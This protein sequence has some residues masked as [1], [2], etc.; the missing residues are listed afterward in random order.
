MLA[1]AR[2]DCIAVFSTNILPHRKRLPSVWAVEERFLAEGQSPL[3]TG[4]A[5]RYRHDIMPHAVEPMDAADDPEINIIVLWFGR[6]MAKT[7]GV[8]GNIVGRTVTDDPGNIYAMGP[9]DDSVYQF[10]RD[11]IEPM[12]ESTP[13]LQ[14]VFVEK[15]SRD[16]G[17]TVD[18]KRFAGGSLYIVNAGSPSKMRGMA[19]KVVLIREVDAFPASTKNEGDPVEKALGRAEGFGDAIK[20]LESTGTLAP[21]FDADGVKK[22]NSRI[23]QWYER[24]DQRKWFCPCRVC[25]RLQWLKFEQI[26]TLTRKRE[27]EFYLCE[28]CDADHNEAQWRRMVLS[29]KWFPTA[30]L[31]EIDLSDIANTF[32]KARAANPAVRSYWINGFNSLLPKGKGYR[33]K[34]TQFVE[35][36][37][38][39]AS[40]PEAKRVWINEVDTTL[41]DPTAEGE[42]PPEWKPVYDRREDYATPTRIIVPAG[43]LVLCV[44]V[45]VHKNRLEVN[46]G[47]YGRGEE[48]WGILH[49]VLMGEVQDE[50]VWKELDKELQREF[51]H[52]LGNKI[53]LS[54]GLID[55]GKW[56]EWI[57]YFLRM[58][59]A[60]GSPVAGRV[61]ACRG[62]SKF[63]HPLIDSRYTS[64]A[65]QLKGHWIGGDEAK[66]LIYTRLR[67]APKE[68]GSLPTGWRHYPMSYGQVHFEQ[69]MSERVTIEYAGGEEIRRYKNEA[70]AR[71][72]TLDAEVYQLGA[73][74]LRRWNMDAIEAELT[75]KEEPPPE[76]K[77]VRQRSG[78]SF[79]DWK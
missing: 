9:T 31:S 34:L 39:V 52:E 58:I 14:K 66:D 43:A 29:A 56:P 51:Q 65:K 3:S 49:N 77:P 50:H 63:P 42:K 69:L 7:E 12:I 72:E 37:A 25:G 64:I 55:A 73:F 16:S 57:Y 33:T 11:M 21:T 20:V 48:Y 74:R 6:R 47:A 59:R 27:T 18:Y 35:E 40:D 45:D 15:K 70:H 61:R 10:S 41:W 8:C 62:A 71:N 60:T 38:R 13:A 28:K 5:I 23:H 53:G 24:G 1:K 68:D 46:W 54:F 67:L 32:K 75:R 76:K 2:E 22:Y 4:H 79:W 30:G 26:K 36:A 19:A 78:S 17:R 44:G